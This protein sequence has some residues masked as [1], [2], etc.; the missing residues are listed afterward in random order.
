MA[1]PFDWWPGIQRDSSNIQATAKIIVLIQIVI[2]D[3]EIPREQYC[4][5]F[6]Q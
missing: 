2:E 6:R 3:P 4:K 5:E 1:R